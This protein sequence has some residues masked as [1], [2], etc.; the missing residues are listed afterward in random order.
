MKNVL[1]YSPKRRYTPVQA[2]CHPFFDE[3][4]QKNVYQQLKEQVKLPDLFNFELTGEVTAEERLKLIPKW[5]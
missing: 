1:C 3:L 4:R 2:L 5:Y